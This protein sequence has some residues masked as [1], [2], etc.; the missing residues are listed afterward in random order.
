MLAIK[1]QFL[2]EYNFATLNSV[3]PPPEVARLLP[4]E[5]TYL[6]HLSPS[7][8]HQGNN[9]VYAFGFDQ[10]SSSWPSDITT[11]YTYDFHHTNG[12]SHRPSY[13]PLVPYPPPHVH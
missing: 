10:W 12:Y 8:L 2:L 9:P 6:I 5:N 13:M 1:L 4:V 11:S 7:A 3:L